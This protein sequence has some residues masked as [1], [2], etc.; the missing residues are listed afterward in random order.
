MDYSVLEKFWNRIKVEYNVVVSFLATTIFFFVTHGYCMANY[1]PS[2]DG[3]MI[4]ACDDVH[5]FSLGRWLI[6]YY[7]EYVRNRICNNWFTLCIACV[8]IA[9]IV[10][11]I[12]N[13]LEMKKW[14]IV[15]LAGIL[16]TNITLVCQY[17]TFIPWADTEALAAMFTC[18]S[19]LI[20]DKSKSLKT[21]WIAPVLICLSMGFYAAYVDFA[22]GLI[23]LVMV[24]RSLKGGWAFA[25]Y[26]K[27]GLR[28]LAYF[29][30][31]GVLYVIVTKLM[32][33]KTGIPMAD[34][35]N[36]PG[37]LLSL[38]FQQFVVEIFKGIGNAYGYM[39][40][41]FF[42]KLSSKEQGVYILL[43]LAAFIM[44]VIR[45]VK[46]RKD[47]S[48]II[49]T[50]IALVIFTMG[51]NAILF[52]S[53]DTIHRLMVYSYNL[54][55]VLFLVM[56][57]F[58][59][60]GKVYDIARAATVILLCVYFFLAMRFAGNVYLYRHQVFE[61][62]KLAAYDV[63]TDVCKMPGFDKDE[64]EILVVYGG[65][66]ENNFSFIE[67]YMESVIFPEGMESGLSSSAISHPST[68]TWF[69]NFNFGVYLKWTES[70]EE[71]CSNSKIE[72]MPCYPYEGYIQWVDDKLV[73]KLSR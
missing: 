39:A 11:A 23:L 34:G 71:F 47:K 31:G 32:T 70:D 20:V 9:V 65:T 67:P 41:Y 49:E 38:S 73:V 18:L 4:V 29:L 26:V 8:A 6:P 24:Y 63:Y 50:L 46:L 27:Y 66:K 69:Y 44:L 36:G 56:A 72:E 57:G 17:A 54:V 58:K 12:S 10:A 59:E 3:A 43:F 53:M 48:A 62:T 60:E 61:K 42:G 1:S 52:V 37:R 55:L 68:R 51:I 16:T 21:T 15:L 64:T 14:Q 5:Q 13:L 40:D 22:L 7:Y 28:Q 2:H 19:V 33:I 45:L 30:A 35:Y 25:D